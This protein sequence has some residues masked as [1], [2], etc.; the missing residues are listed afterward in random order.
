MVIVWRV[1]EACG[2]ACP[3]CGYSRELPF[4]RKQADVD[5]VLAFGTVLRDV[6]QA[7]GRSILVSWLGGEPLAWSAL[8]GVSEFFQAQCGLRLGVTTNGVPLASSSVRA[9]LLRHFEQVTISIDGAT[10]FHD[11]IRRQSGLYDAVRASVRSLCKEDPHDRLLRRVN[12]VL[13]RD[14]VA[15]FAEFCETMASWGFHEM[16]FNQLGGI[17]RPEFFAANRLLPA[18]V[19]RFARDLPALRERTKARGMSICGSDAYVQRIE[20]SAAGQRLPIDDCLPATEFLF[21]DTGG[22]ISPCSFTHDTYGKP[23]S[24]ITSAADFLALPHTFQKLRQCHRATA[25]A[26]CH[27]THVFAKFKRLTREFGGANE[28]APA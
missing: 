1:T 14:N 7:S 18:Q 6:Q 10:Q 4:L 2:L 12:T 17:E 19:E 22:I 20:A 8:A 3:F 11:A 21:I 13:M 23:I 24:A 27:A 26:D 28:R 25:C 16:S 15:H 9:C 5:Q